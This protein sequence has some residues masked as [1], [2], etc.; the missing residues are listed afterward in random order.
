[1]VEDAHSLTYVHDSKKKK[2]QKYKNTKKK[3]QHLMFKLPSNRTWHMRCHVM[4]TLEGSK[5]FM[6]K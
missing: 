6:E 4:C 1:M 3:V 2:E 5:V